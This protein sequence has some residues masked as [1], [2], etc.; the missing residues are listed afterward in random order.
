MI[1]IDDAT[2]LCGWSPRQFVTRDI[3]APC[4]PR[5]SEE[6]FS[7]LADRVEIVV[8]HYFAVFKNCDQSVLVLQFGTLD[9]FH[10]SEFPWLGFNEGKASGSVTG[11]LKTGCHFP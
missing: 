3:G 4:T 1:A 8:N 5:K 6:N 10:R 11:S 2:R 9:V 7:T